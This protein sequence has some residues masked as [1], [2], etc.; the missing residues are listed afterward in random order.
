M[1]GGILVYLLVR[2]LT[3]KKMQ[4]QK[5]WCCNRLFVFFS[6]LD[7]MCV[8]YGVSICVGKTTQ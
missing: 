7:N 4:G 3:I 1:I 6:L 2:I 5:K 8:V